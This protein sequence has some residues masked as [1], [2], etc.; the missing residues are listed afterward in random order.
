[1]YFTSSGSV[2][3]NGV[4]LDFYAM[5]YFGGL[6]FGLEDELTGVVK[7]TGVDGSLYGVTYYNS[8]DSDQ[9]VVF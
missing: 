4:S 6:S 5:D 8:C 2:S 7:V 3:Y 1:M 9:I